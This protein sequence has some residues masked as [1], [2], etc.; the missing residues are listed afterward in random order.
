MNGDGVVDHIEA[1]GGGGDGE[2]AA[3]GADGR[4]VPACW[5]SA[6]SGVPAREHLFNGSICRGSAGVTRHGGRHYNG[7]DEIRN[8]SFFS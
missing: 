3:V 6:T 1:H 4:P 5:A 7:G 2:H 8:A